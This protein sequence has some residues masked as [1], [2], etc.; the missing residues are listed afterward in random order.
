MRE[1]QGICGGKKGKRQRRNVVMAWLGEHARMEFDVR[2]GDKE[3]R[4]EAGGRCITNNASPS[5]IRFDLFVAV[6]GG[7]TASLHLR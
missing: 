1:R 2:H 5:C 4:A 7:K 6:S 3:V